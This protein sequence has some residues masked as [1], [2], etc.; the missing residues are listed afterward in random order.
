MAECALNGW[1]NVRGSYDQSDVQ[2]DAFEE[3]KEVEPRS[4][5]FQRQECLLDLESFRPERCNTMPS[6]IESFWRLWRGSSAVADNTTEQTWRGGSY[7]RGCVRRGIGRFRAA[8]VYR[9]WLSVDFQRD[10][11][12]L[13]VAPPRIV[14]ESIQD[15]DGFAIETQRTFVLGLILAITETVRAIRPGNQ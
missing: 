8:D 10:P 11:S 15:W 2:F 12:E 14:A 3:S 9:Y 6:V 7:S 1:D 5:E 4:I 13:N